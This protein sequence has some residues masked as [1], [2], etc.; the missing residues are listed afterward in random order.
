MAYAIA[1]RKAKMFTVLAFLSAV[2]LNKDDSA[3]H[4]QYS[5]LAGIVIRYSCAFVYFS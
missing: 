5:F 1:L 3:G 2:G 4:T